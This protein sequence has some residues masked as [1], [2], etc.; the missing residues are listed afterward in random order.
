MKKFCDF[1]KQDIEVRNYQQFNVHKLYCLYNPKRN[2]FLKKLSQSC[3]LPK[4]K[5]VF[6][7]RK[8]NKKYKLFLNE[9]QFDR[10]EYRKHCSR[11]CA[12]SRKHTD[13]TK[14]KISKKLR[15][16]RV[17]IKCNWCKKDVDIPDY[18]KDSRK[19]CSRGCATKSRISSLDYRNNLSKSLK[20]KSGGYRIGSGVG[21]KSWYISPI[22]GRVHLDSSYEL[23]YAKYLDQNNMDWRKNEQKFPYHWNNQILYYIPD[24][25][26]M[27]KQEYTE[28]KGFQTKKDLAKWAEFPNKLNV[29][30]RKD[31]R[32]LGLKI[33]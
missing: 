13:I 11:K 20:G 9:H 32:N 8:C 6:H 14:E 29:L 17:I 12:N 5:Y 19:F 18:L 30:Y 25:Y 16:K 31:L 22:A 21:K 3:T 15:A 10:N 28:I 23:A 27:D 33:I 4:Y 1:C 7:C 24:F 26:M 2:A